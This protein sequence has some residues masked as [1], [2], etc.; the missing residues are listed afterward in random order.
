MQFALWQ[1]APAKILTRQE[2]AHVLADLKQKAERS[3]ND[4][5]NL[6]L[7]HLATCC[8]LRVSEVAKLRLDEVDLASRRP[9]IVEIPTANAHTFGSVGALAGAMT[10]PD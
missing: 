7:F 6:I 10:A 5:L 3:R 1:V 8:G 2:L 9:N 4:R